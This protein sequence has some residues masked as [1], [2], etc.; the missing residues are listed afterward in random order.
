MDQQISRC[1]SNNSN[2]HLLFTQRVLSARLVFR[3]FATLL[4]YISKVQIFLTLKLFIVD[5]LENVPFF[6]KT[7]KLKKIQEMKPWRYQFFSVSNRFKRRALKAC[8]DLMMFRCSR[9]APGY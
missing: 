3:N 8:P 5:M 4:I 9:K 1:P 6:Q 7:A 2:S